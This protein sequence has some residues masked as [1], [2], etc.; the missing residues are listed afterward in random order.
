MSRSESPRH[1]TEEAVPPARHRVTVT[2]EATLVSSRRRERFQTGELL[3]LLEGAATP[4]DSTFVRVN[5]LRPSRGVE[6]RYVVPSGEFQ[7]KTETIK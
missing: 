1:K 2:F 6:C 4:T 7:E 5:G 3:M